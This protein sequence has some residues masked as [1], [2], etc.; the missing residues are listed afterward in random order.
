MA[1][2]FY[3]SDPRR[4]RSDVT[5]RL[6]H[7]PRCAAGE[8]TALL[9][10]H[11][12][13]VYS[14][15][16]AGTGIGAVEWPGSVVLIGPNHRGRGA[17]VAVS[18]AAAWRTPLGDVRVETGLRDDLLRELPEAELDAEAHAREHA[19]EVIV[20]FLQVA[21]PGVS[22]VCVSLGLADLDLCLTTGRALARIVKAG[23]AR[24]E[25]PALVVSSDLNHY[26]PRRENRAKDVRAL[27][28]LLRGDPG[29][30]FGRVLGP[31]EI[32]MCG[33]LPATALLE[34]LR[35]LPPTRPSLLAHGDSADTSGDESHVVGYAT[36]L[37]THV[38]RKEPA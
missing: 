6:G 25:A 31:E 10:P 34:A 29:E 37:W 14:G 5:A 27:D 26:L 3:E 9:L 17:P 8:W 19:L 13:H 16:I 32:S 21:R 20:P 7:G 15:A 33:V 28:A 30:L 38:D 23:S 2:L 12:G 11:A 4:L 24:G 22:I 35:H 36:V 1:G 18:P